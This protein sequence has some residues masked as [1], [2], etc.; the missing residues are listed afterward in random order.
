MSSSPAPSS[1]ARNASLYRS[2]LQEAA[3]AGGVMMGKLVAAA[4]QLLQAREAASRELRER[5]RSELDELL[6]RIDIPVLMIT[7]DPEDLA[8]SATLRSACA[9]AG[10]VKTA[11]ETSSATRRDRP[12]GL[13]ETP[14]LRIFSSMSGKSDSNG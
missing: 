9:M 7:H 12:V 8:C 14:K 4:R 6:Q 10:T 13:I 1:A 5:M 2:T 3:A 11:S